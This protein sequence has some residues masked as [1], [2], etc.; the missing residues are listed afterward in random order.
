MELEL[1]PFL[2]LAVVGI[3]WPEFYILLTCISV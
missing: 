1:R 2:T 3:N